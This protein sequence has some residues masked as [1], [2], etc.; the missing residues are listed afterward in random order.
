MSLSNLPPDVLRTAPGRHPWS[1]RRRSVWPVLLLIAGL[2]AVAACGLAIDLKVS[3]EIYERRGLGVLHPSLEV[4]RGFGDAVGVLL[5]GLLIYTL[6]YTRR[7]NLPRMTTIALAAGGM[8]DVL[9]LLIC[10]VRPHHSDLTGSVYSTFE[11]WLPGLSAGSNGQSFPS[12]HTATAIGLALGLSWLYPRGR[13]MF[14]ALAV[15]VGLQRVEAGAHYLSDVLCGA[16]I[17]VACALVCFRGPY[18][19][20]FFARLERWLRLN[21]QA[22]LNR[23]FA[24]YA[25]GRS[26]V[27]VRIP[28]IVAEDLYGATARVAEAAGSRARSATEAHADQLH[29]A[30]SAA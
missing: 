26:N 8:V 18:M 20:R 2:L 22:R 5:I 11:G 1:N 28:G 9:K 29:I 27:P 15:L 21:L 13:T 23:R 7:P 14:V 19:G 10:R 3:R 6:D 30:N 16:A 17:G 4:V 24:A 12:G 25:A